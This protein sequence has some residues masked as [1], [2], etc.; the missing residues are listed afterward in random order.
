MDLT[1]EFPNTRDD[2][3]QLGLRHGDG[4]VETYV[5]RAELE[6]FLDMQLKNGR[7]SNNPDHTHLMENDND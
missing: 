5:F 1:A 4:R 3:G 6:K 7:P 2:R